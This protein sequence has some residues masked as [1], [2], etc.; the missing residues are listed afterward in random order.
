MIRLIGCF[1]VTASVFFDIYSYWKQVAKTLREKE[2]KDVSTSAYL[3]KIVHYLCS[4][5]ALVIFMNWA[6]LV[7][8]TV[9]LICCLVVLA[10]V[11]KYKPKNWKL[12]K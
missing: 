12:F 4:I 9:P 1:L 5:G 11:A 10:V 7:I 6:G 2:S 8:E 3:M